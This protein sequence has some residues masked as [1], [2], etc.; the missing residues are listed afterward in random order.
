[1]DAIVFVV[2]QNPVSVK[3]PLRKNR[4]RIEGSGELVKGKATAMKVSP[5]RETEF[6][7]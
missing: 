6:T 7:K 3:K 1:M 5:K 4:E 2:R